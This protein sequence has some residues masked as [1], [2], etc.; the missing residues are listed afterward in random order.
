MSKS[1]DVFFSLRAIFLKIDLAHLSR[2]KMF[3]FKNR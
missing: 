1:Y 2:Q 3:E